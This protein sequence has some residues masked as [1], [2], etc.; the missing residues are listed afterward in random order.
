MDD[1]VKSGLKGCLTVFFVIGVILSYCF[2]CSHDRKVA[3]QER[4]WEEYNSRPHIIAPIRA[5]GTYRTT[6]PTK[7]FRP[8]RDSESAPG[9][10]PWRAAGYDSFEDWYYA[11]MDIFGADEYPDM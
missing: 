4:R 1:D 11:E 8:D 9:Q 10:E 7:T 3:E 5:P 2:Q 6:P